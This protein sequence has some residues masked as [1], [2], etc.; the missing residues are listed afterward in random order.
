[1]RLSVLLAVLPFALGAPA[2]EQRSEP[3]PL[4][5]ARGE[6]V[7]N[8]YIVKLKEGSALANL[9]NTMSKL[10]GTPD[11]VFKNVFK[12]F[13]ATLDAKTL[14]LLRAHPDVNATKIR[15]IVTTLTQN[16]SSTLSRMLLSPSLLRSP[17]L[18]GAL[19]ASPAPA[20]EPPPTTTMTPPALAPAPT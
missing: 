1:M 14:D 4:L 7:A 6:L 18:L 13:A 9:E 20:L 15:F 8:K 19:P 11:A 5:E 12:G 3:A 2:V 17:M 10:T 16:R